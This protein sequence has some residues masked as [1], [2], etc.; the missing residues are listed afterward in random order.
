MAGVGGCEGEDA[1]VRMTWTVSFWLS[2]QVLGRDVLFVKE[3]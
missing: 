2:W 3:K 1:A